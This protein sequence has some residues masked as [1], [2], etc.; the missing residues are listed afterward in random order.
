VAWRLAVALAAA[1]AAG[2]AGGEAPPAP[3][4]PQ[5]LRWSELTFKARKL[6][7]TAEIR[8][9]AELVPATTAAAE[10][11]EADVLAAVRPAGDE[12][13][14]LELESSLLGR[15]STNTVLLDPGSAAALQSRSRESGKRARVKTQRFTAEGIAVAR[16]RPAEGEE[17]LPEER[18][19]RRST[20]LVPLPVGEGGP[21]VSDSVALFW[22]LATAPLERPG[23]AHHLRLVSEGRLLEVT[24][25]VV[26][27][28]QRHLE[29]AERQGAVRR[30]LEK[31]VQA[32]ELAVD[33]AP[34]APGGSGDD[35]EFLGMKGS[36]RIVLD[37][38][39]RAP[40]EVSGRVPGAGTVVV[41]LQ[42]VTLR[43]PAQP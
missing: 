37:P 23:D 8:V 17:R 21:A 6:I 28:V 25:K 15:H 24:V 12:A 27:L 1:L 35:L 22:V 43:E 19:S 32:L 42:G 31:T 10:M 26:R 3:L 16:A 39:R 4:S 29:I 14:R 18:W 11:E 2:A 30:H 40:I 41:R 33:A 13:V 36:V 5:R 20:E 9:E 38:E 7:F 34:V